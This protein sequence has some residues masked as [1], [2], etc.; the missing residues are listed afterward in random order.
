MNRL[1]WAIAA[2]AGVIGFIVVSWLIS[3]M[4]QQKRPPVKI[5]QEIPNASEKRNGEN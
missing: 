5:H 2:G 3:I 1:N 4:R